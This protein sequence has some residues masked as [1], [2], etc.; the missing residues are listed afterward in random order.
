M[1]CF[2]IVVWTALAGIYCFTKSLFK[3][4]M[5]KRISA[6]LNGGNIFALNYL[7]LKD[8]NN[9]RKLGAHSGL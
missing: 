4:K 8:I 6:L 5:E 1:L 3:N 2:L 9:F 7:M